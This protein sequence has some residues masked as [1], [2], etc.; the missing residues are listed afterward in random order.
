MRS[1]DLAVDRNCQYHPT[2]RHD[3]A[4]PDPFSTRNLLSWHPYDP[5]YPA[6]WRVMNLVRRHCCNWAPVP[7]VWA[8]SP[9]DPKTTI[10]RALR[11]AVKKHLARSRAA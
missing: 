9:G 6:L 2:A 4:W 3:N 10:K 1:L 5:S 11:T 8:L 7:I